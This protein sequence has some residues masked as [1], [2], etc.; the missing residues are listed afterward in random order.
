VKKPKKY[1]ILHKKLKA[2]EEIVLDNGTMIANDNDHRVRLLI[3][4]PRT[5]YI[6]SKFCS[7]V[8]VL[9]KFDALDCGQLVDVFAKESTANEEKEKVE[10]YADVSYACVYPM[11][12]L[13]SQLEVYGGQESKEEA[14]G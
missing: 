11:R 4:T 6:P 3:K 14:D 7:K 9:M 13:S 8:F 10:Q 2:G 12:V 1:S 5:N